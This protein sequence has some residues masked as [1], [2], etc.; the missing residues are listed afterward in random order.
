MQEENLEFLNKERME[1]QTYQMIRKAFL[2]EQEFQRLLPGQLTMS[3]LLYGLH[4]WETKA[5][6]ILY[7]SDFDLSSC[8]LN[9]RNLNVK[10]GG[11]LA[12]ANVANS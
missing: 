7:F 6:S 3:A 11:L 8:L 10:N 4:K 5:A 12:Q 1:C 9:V 2:L